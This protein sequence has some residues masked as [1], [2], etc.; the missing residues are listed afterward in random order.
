MNSASFAP[1]DTLPQLLRERVRRSP[2]AP[3]YWTRD[4]SG[5]WQALSWQQADRRVA[6]IARRL[7]QQG[8]GKGSTIGILA[9]TSLDWELCQM[10]LLRL[11]AV[12]V[13]LDPM[14]RRD[15]LATMLQLARLDGLL[16]APPIEPPDAQLHFCLSL[17]FLA[18]PPDDDSLQTDN[19]PAEPLLTAADPAFILFTS[20]TT[21][22]PKGL[23]YRH[24]QVCL[25][26]EALINAFNLREEDGPRR[27]ACWLP[28]ANLFQ[29]ILNFCA[30]RLG[31][32]TY[33]VEQ[34]T[35]IVRLLPQIAPHILIG[36]PRFFEKLDAGLRSQLQQQ[37]WPMRPLLRWATAERS[38]TSSDNRPSPW[39]RASQPLRSVLVRR[40]RQALFGRNLLFAVTGS[41]AMPVWLLER[42]R[43]LGV[44]LYEAY[45]ISENIVPIALNRPG[46][47][48]PGTV[49][50]VLPP[51]RVRLAE[52]GELLVSGPGLFSGSYL[53]VAEQKASSSILTADGYLP[54]GDLARM[55]SEGFIQLL[56]RKSEIFKTATGRK[57]APTIIESLLCQIPCLDQVALFGANRPCLVA[58]A[59]LA[60][61]QRE[62]AAAAP[63]DWLTRHGDLLRQMLRQTLADLPRYQQPAGLLLT[64]QPFTPQRGELTAN[65]KLRRQCIAD[66]YAADIETLYRQLDQ[67]TATAA[68]GDTASPCL[69]QL[70]IRK[71][72]LP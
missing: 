24:G 58:I 52:D 30:L 33:F 3:A 50:K 12:V 46:A 42:Y 28:L 37:P 57:I 32:Q 26:C 70:A 1:L 36:V 59:V 45:G 67:P 34:P 65:L 16:Y 22:S 27:L 14:E 29:R 61:E 2:Q 48:R 51:N 38:P 18:A 53:T 56:G 19:D 41:A 63:N 20:G 72:P 6:T 15:N 49:G 68:V 44:T 9:P 13:G 11:G 21:G 8:V 17:T 66:H 10:A 35:E 5:H 60:A 64:L 62:T 7:H 47:L 23:L 39:Q 43:Q 54:T 71:E 4:A 40:I 55:D 25:A 69:I 31:A